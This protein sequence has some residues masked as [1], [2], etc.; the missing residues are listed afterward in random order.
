MHSNVSTSTGYV[1]YSPSQETVIVAHQG[2]DPSDLEAD[3]TDLDIV[4]GSLDSTLFPGVDSSVE[5]HEGF[6]DEQAKTATTILSAVQ[7]VIAA[8]SAT[9]VTVVGHSLGSNATAKGAA[10]ALLDGVYLPLHISGVAFQT[11]GYEGDIWHSS[12]YASFLGKNADI[13]ESKFTAQLGTLPPGRGYLPKD[14][15]PTSH[16]KELHAA[17]YRIN[18]DRTE[19]WMESQEQRIHSRHI[20]KVAAKENPLTAGYTGRNHTEDLVSDTDEM[21]HPLVSFQRSRDYGARTIRHPHAQFPTRRPIPAPVDEEPYRFQTS[22]T[23][24]KKYARELRAEKDEII[25]SR[26]A[27]TRPNEDWPHNANIAAPRQNVHQQPSRHAAQRPV[28]ERI[29]HQGCRLSMWGR[30]LHQPGTTDCDDDEE[31]ILYPRMK[32]APPPHP[33]P[34]KAVVHQG[35]HD[36][37]AH[38]RRLLSPPERRRE[39]KPFINEVGD[40]VTIPQ[41]QLENSSEDFIQITAEQDSFDN[42]P[43]C[44]MSIAMGLHVPN[45]VPRRVVYPNS[46]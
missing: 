24:H 7:D 44:E 36:R 22:Q 31:T 33:K 12:S 25:P 29:I 27:L 41:A 15:V 10:L 8:H 35:A 40:L 1:G 39:L 13:W 2:T 43:V 20:A 21:V 37:F 46:R 42:F 4:M 45:P 11:I 34:R 3:L 17:P 38:E 32:A 30:Q 28:N 23:S 19:Y 9:Q 26:R 14:T 18:S 16:L 6:R 5:V